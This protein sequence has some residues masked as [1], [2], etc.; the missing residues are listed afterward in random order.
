M[1]SLGCPGHRSRC[2]FCPSGP[3]CRPV[4]RR[5]EYASDRGR[6]TPLCRFR[7]LLEAVPDAIIEVERDGSVL[8]NAAAERIFGYKCDKLLGQFIEVSVPNSLRHRHQEHRHYYWF[9]AQRRRRADIGK[10]FAAER[11]IRK[12]SELEALLK[13]WD[14]NLELLFGK[15]QSQ[16]VSDARLLVSTTCTGMQNAQESN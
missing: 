5:T 7:K 12:P 9:L 6:H 1:N 15:E 3:D 11:Y 14:N 2:R 16:L 13:H 10:N 8:L 4:E